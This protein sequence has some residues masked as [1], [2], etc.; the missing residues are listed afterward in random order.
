YELLADAVADAL[1][2][3]RRWP[4]NSYDGSMAANARKNELEAPLRA[5]IIRKNELFFHRWRPANSTYL[6]GFRKHEQGQNAKEIP[7][8]DPLIEKAEAEIDRLKK[9]P[10]GTPQPAAATAA[11]AA[12]PTL[13]KPDFTVAD[14]YH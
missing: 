5:T 8:F 14:G 10:A 13:P 7:E 4:D 9:A 3:T 1:Q 6:F 11:P 2:W 12:V